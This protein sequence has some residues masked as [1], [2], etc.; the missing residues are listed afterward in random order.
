MTEEGL[1]L[2]ALRCPPRLDQVRCCGVGVN[3]RTGR[4][5]AFT[6][7]VLLLSPANAGNT[8]GVSMSSLHVMFVTH[9]QQDPRA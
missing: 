9:S 4:R 5:L 1:D 6:G 8:S 3:Q 7:L 2:P